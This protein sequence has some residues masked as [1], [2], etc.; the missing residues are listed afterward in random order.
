M[1][2]IDKPFTI[3]PS[4]VINLV[5]SQTHQFSEADRQM[6][7]EA[8]K[9]G[10]AIH[11][12]IEYNLTH[13]HDNPDYLTRFVWDNY[14]PPIATEKT[15]SVNL[16]SNVTLFAK[17]D[18]VSGNPG[19]NCLC[20]EIKPGK[21]GKPVGGLQGRYVFQAISNSISLS[22][23]KPADVA[24]HLYESGRLVIL[25]PDIQTRLVSLVRQIAVSASR[26]IYFEGYRHK[27]KDAGTIRR[28]KPDGQLYLFQP[29]QLSPEYLEARFDLHGLG[30]EIFEE[31]RSIF[32]P[33]LAEFKDI[34]RRIS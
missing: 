14:P 32:N 26:I 21:K 24:I 19:Q 1:L 11:K 33:A 9:R 8:S 31:Y 2:E 16:G 28:K 34:C 13:H 12:Q 22:E 17:P 27:L 10:R 4:T 29:D 5:I 15:Y 23:H 6:A 3:N 30:A 7:V 25:S 20:L 18:I